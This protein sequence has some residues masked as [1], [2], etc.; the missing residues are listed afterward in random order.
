MTVGCAVRCLLRSG[1]HRGHRSELGLECGVLCL[2]LS[3]GL[4]RF[5]REL[6]R[7]VG[8]EERLELLGDCAIE[9]VEAPVEL[10]NCGVVVPLDGEAHG[11]LAKGA[12]C[13]AGEAACR[14]NVGIVAARVLERGAV[15][16]HRGPHAERVE[17]V[18]SHAVDGRSAYAIAGGL[19]LGS[20]SGRNL[21]STHGI[22]IAR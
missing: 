15:R 6:Q 13:A 12:R 19:G 3:E 9:V 2:H 4:A 8:D 10:G 14:K 5:N 16:K 20:G 7:H 11:R 17:A 21:G 1:D 22:S 18:G